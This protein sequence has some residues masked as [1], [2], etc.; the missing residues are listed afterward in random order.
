MKKRGRPVG[1]LIRQRILKIIKE[2]T[3]PMYGYQIFSK[4]K[5][6]YPKVSMRLVYYHIKKSLSLGEIK[7]VKIK[8]EKGKYSW[9]GEVERVYYSI[10]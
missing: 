4:Y 6:Q 1:S 2:S 8:K 9:G 3:I 7:V 10:K 5:K